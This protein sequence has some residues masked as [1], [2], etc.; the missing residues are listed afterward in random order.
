MVTLCGKPKVEKQ[1][2]I[3]GCAGFTS[4]RPLI[5][6]TPRSFTNEKCAF[7]CHSTDIAVLQWM[8]AISQECNLKQY[9]SVLG[10]FT[11]FVAILQ[12]N[13]FNYLTF[14]FFFL[15]ILFDTVVKQCTKG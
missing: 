14:F 15:K 12:A 8:Q 5:K 3:K 13:N 7:Y 4:N 10:S 11:H 1:N 9:S 6:F 2:K